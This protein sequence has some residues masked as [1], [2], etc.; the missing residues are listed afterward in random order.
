MLIEIISFLFFGILFGIFTGLAPGI[1]INLVSLILVSLSSSLLVFVNPIY[2][3]VFIVAMSITHTFV[4]FIPSIFLGAPEDGTE[5]SVLPGH[6][7]LKSGRGYEAVMLTNLGGLAAI[8][9]LILISFPLVFFV[10]KIYN[11]IS[12]F[13]PFILI[14]VSLFMIFSEGEKLSSL[15]VFLLSGILGLIVLNLDGLNQP[16]LPLLSGLFGASALFL[17]IKAKTQVPEQVIT[18][19]EIRM[20]K[21]LAGSLVSSLICGFLPGLGSGQA[22]IIGNLISKSGREEFLVLLG[23]TNTL[24]MGLSFIAVY[25]IQKARTGAAASVQ[26]I[27]GQIPKEILVLI[28][29]VVLIS[30]ILSFFITKILAEFF[31]NKIE[32]INYTKLSIATIF[33][34]SAIVFFV[35][36]F[37]G[38]FVFFVSTMTG[39]FCISANVK[40]TL[41]MSCLLLPTIVLYLT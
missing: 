5:L 34:L 36:G 18:K 38:F 7:L 40:R 35:S 29:I 16:L 11:F 27:F 4:D 25:A 22:A 20:A 28:L 9:I 31:S 37:L 14:A 26:E 17:T 3:I 24:V 2:F 19:P 8:F 13:I 23:S 41:M 6:E 12:E 33:F 39:I 21:P 10:P 30:G 1:H 32:K 15:I